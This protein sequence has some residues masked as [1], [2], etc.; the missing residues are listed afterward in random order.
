ML[1]GR[2]T[3]F[4]AVALLC[5]TLLAAC[6]DDAGDSTPTPTEPSRTATPRPTASPTATPA[7]EPNE[8]PERDLV[9]LARRF[10]GLPAGAPV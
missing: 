4:Q 10:R 8:P 9:D 7:S 1:T 3:V 5:F 6:G 2:A